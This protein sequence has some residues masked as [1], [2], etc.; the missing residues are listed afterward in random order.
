MIHKCDDCQVLTKEI[1]WYLGKNIN[2]FRFGQNPNPSIYGQKAEKRLRRKKPKDASD[3]L[4][5]WRFK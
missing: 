1:I 3:S 4:K 2:I 5:G